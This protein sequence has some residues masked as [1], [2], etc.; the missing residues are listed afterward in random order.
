MIAGVVLHTALHWRWITA[1]VRRLA[2]DTRT[3]ARPAATA[4]ASAAASAALQ[5]AARSGL[6]RNAFLR[7]AGF[8]AGAALVDGIVGRSAGGAAVSWLDGSASSDGETTIASS[9]AEDSTDGWTDDSGSSAGS[10]SDGQGSANATG[11]DQSAQAT[12][13]TARVAI[14]AGRCT[15]CGACLQVCPYG[16]FSTDGRTVVVA[17]AGACRLCGRCTQACPAGAITLNG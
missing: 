17:D 8:V 5:P 7:R 13:P 12:T 16:V 1:M 11:G 9:L 10:S 4:H 14:D 15:G 3:E 6:T 2:R